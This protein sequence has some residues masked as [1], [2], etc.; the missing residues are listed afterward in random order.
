MELMKIVE[1]QC[2]VNK[3]LLDVKHIEKERD[4]KMD[5]KYNGIKLI[6]SLDTYIYKD[7]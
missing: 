4:M 5:K 6:T 1:R 7:T 2:K 3:I